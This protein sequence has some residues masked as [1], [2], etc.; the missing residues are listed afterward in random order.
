MEEQPSVISAWSSDMSKKQKVEGG[1]Q[2]AQDL[3]P[4]PTSCC[5]NLQI[6]PHVFFMNENLNDQGPLSYSFSPL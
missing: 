3:K 2:K 6:H 1:L 4:E 5:S